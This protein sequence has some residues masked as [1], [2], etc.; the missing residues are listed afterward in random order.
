MDFKNYRQHS[1]EMGIAGGY[2]KLINGENKFR[3][4]TSPEPYVSHFM[5]KGQPVLPCLQNCDFC[6]KGYERTVKVIM[7]ILDRT[8]NQIKL[9]ELGWSI[10]KAI[11]ELANSS[12]YGFESIPPYDLIIKR[13]GEGMQTRYIVTP[14]RNEIPLT[15]DQKSELANKTPVKQIISNRMEKIA[16][17]PAQST[18]DDI[19]PFL[20][21]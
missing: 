8:D 7:Y 2:F 21:N 20:D 1:K 11:G 18:E 3:V 12:E 4:L 9:A 19:P 6:K 14:S 16:A 13:T 10:F 5:G 17:L 15:E